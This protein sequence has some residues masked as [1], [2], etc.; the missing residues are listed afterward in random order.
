MTKK[1]HTKSKIFFKNPY[2]VRVQ[3]DPNTREDVEQ[4]YRKIWKRAYREIKGTWG[5]SPLELEHVPSKAEDNT[6]GFNGV[7]LQMLFGTNFFYRGY[8]CFKDEIDALQFRLSI[9][10]TSTHVNMWPSRLFTIHE[11]EETD[12]A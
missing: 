8:F 1:L 10:T 6:A 7:N 12:G 4:A 5:Y 2:V 11:L 3:F 9:D